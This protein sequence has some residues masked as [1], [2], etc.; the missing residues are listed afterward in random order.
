MH[1]KT[2]L[3]TG[4]CLFVCCCCFNLGTHLREFK[5]SF[6]TRSVK[7]CHTAFQC[8]SLFL[9]HGMSGDTMGLHYPWLSPLLAHVFTIAYLVESNTVNNV[10]L[11]MSKDPELISYFP[12]TLKI[13]VK[14]SLS[15]IDLFH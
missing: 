12:C 3:Q 6:E 8:L 5:K 2:T 1:N 10:F 4:G 7:H 9:L 15:P 11:Q 14:S 13:V